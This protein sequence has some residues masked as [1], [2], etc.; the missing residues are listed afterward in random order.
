[1]ESKYQYNRINSD[2]LQAYDGSFMPELPF[3]D[4]R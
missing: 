3:R 2:C 1:L 4:P